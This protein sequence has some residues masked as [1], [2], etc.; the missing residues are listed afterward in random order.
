MTEHNN[1]LA[2]NLGVMMLYFLW[3]WEWVERRVE[4]ITFPDEVTVQ[5]RVSVD[6]AVPTDLTSPLPLNHDGLPTF[7]T[8]LALLEKQGLTNFDLRDEGNNALPLLTREHNGHLVRE[9]LVHL[10]E[11]IHEDRGSPL[12]GGVPQELRRELGLLATQPPGA[13]LVIWDSLEQAK[14]RDG[15]RESQSSHDWRKF[16]VGEDK[17]M[18]LT[19]DFAVGFPLIVPV[20]G[21]AGTRRIVKF[22]YQAPATTHRPSSRTRQVSRSLGWY[23]RTERIEVPSISQ[24]R[25]FHLEVQAPEGLQITRGKLDSSVVPETGWRGP[26]AVSNP[27]PE[28]VHMHINAPPEA[29]GTAH[30]NLRA[31]SSTISR[32]ALSTGVL[33]TL[34]LFLT[35]LHYE[36]AQANVGAAVSLLLLVPT[37]LSI[38]VAR[39]REPVITT[40]LLLGQRVLA[41]SCGI[42][43]IIASAALV[44][45]EDCNRFLFTER[46]EPWSA[47]PSIL[48]ALTV[49]AVVLTVILAITARNTGRP[50]EKAGT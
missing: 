19:K 38:Y 45:G 30:V 25:C 39:P 28:W 50:P 5:R 40:G 44:V 8:P 42:L 21:E 17:F 22:S 34:S 46:C 6:F 49:I 27:G 10:A 35:Y 7:F 3:D 12:P 1:P 43:A 14:E 13:A 47:L 29:T 41:V 37:A 26:V 4:A 24:A 15:R 48:G 11:A 18:T 32:A 9:T 2:K 33:T 36:A 31:R 20:T 16:L 23:P